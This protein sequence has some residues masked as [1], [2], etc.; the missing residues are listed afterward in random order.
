MWE[1]MEVKKTWRAVL[2][3]RGKLQRISLDKSLSGGRS[4]WAGTG[5]RE[6]SGR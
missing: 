3:P 2:L 4:E 5:S 6:G 1:A